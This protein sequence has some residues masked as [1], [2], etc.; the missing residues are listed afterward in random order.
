MSGGA[1]SRSAFSTYQFS[2]T[3]AMFSPTSEENESPSSM[4]INQQFQF[5]Q[6][7]PE[8]EN[9]NKSFDQVR[10][11]QKV[12]KGRS[13]ANY[14]ILWQEN[15]SP[16]APPPALPPKKSK[17][18]IKSVEYRN[19]SP[20]SSPVVEEVPSQ[21]PAAVTPI[22]APAPA[23]SNSIESP[24]LSIDDQCQD[25]YLMD[26]SPMLVQND[27]MSVTSPSHNRS[28]GSNEAPAIKGGEPHLL[29][30]YAASPDLKGEYLAF[31]GIA[32]GGVIMSNAVCFFIDA[33]FREV[34]LLTYRTY[35]RPFDVVVLLWRRYQHFE[36]KTDRPSLVH[37]RATLDL[38][39]DLVSSLT[40]MDLDEE[41]VTKLRDCIYHLVSCGEI[42]SALKARKGLIQ[43]Y[44][45]RQK[46]LS[47]KLPPVALAITTEGQS[48]L[49]WSATSIAQQMTLLDAELFRQLE[50]AELLLWAKEQS[51]DLC[52]A[53]NNFTEHF[54]KVSYW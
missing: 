53:L 41:M 27:L 54:N 42:Q 50:P 22:H 28:G 26:A 33:R 13:F 32:A 21:V 5:K 44:Q 40:P 10:I 20:L 25:L 15:G 19:Q 29:I 17:N 7:S 18:F 43:K 3:A 14:D 8:S 47:P 12:M 36:K 45:I 30:V 16:S 24:Q 48:L 35:V 6:L 37:A 51:E 4:S 39:C 49:Q 52:P 46:L 34:F 31:G 38:F 9:S 2:Y 11:G 23:N 1:F